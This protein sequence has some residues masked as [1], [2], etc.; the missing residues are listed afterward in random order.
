MPSRGHV[1]QGIAPGASAI[2]WTLWRPGEEDSVPQ[3]V[4]AAAELD[5]DLM[6]EGHGA[7]DGL[8]PDPLVVGVGGGDLVRGGQERREAV[9]HD[10]E[11]PE[12][13]ALRRPRE[14]LG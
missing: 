13:D 3:S 7:P 9:G 11:G 14:H 6:E 12:E 1:Y 2:G 5:H 4:P 8:L 10:P